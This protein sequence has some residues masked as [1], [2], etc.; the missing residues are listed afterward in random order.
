MTQVGLSYENSL[1]ISHLCFERAQ[2]C[3]AGQILVY[4][5]VPLIRAFREL[6]TVPQESG[7]DYGQGAVYGGARLRQ[8]PW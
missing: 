8:V 2:S 1:D 4:L 7:H 3:E 5:S 6:M